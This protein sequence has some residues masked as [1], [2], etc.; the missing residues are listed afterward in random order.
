MNVRFVTGILAVAAGLGAVRPGV[1]ASASMLSP[2]PQWMAYTRVPQ[3][4]YPGSS[5]A[6]DSNDVVHWVQAWFDQD[7]WQ[8]EIRYRDTRYTGRGINGFSAKP[9]IL[10]SSPQGAPSSSPDVA[11]GPDGSVHVVWIQGAEGGNRSS[12]Y[13]RRKTSTGWDLPMELVPT[14]ERRHYGK[15]QIHVDDSGQI[16]VVATLSYEDA[17]RNL[18][19]GVAYIGPGGSMRELTDF[20]VATTLRLLSADAVYDIAP[21]I[22]PVS[23]RAICSIRRSSFL[24]CL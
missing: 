17:N 1:P 20:R 21:R 10:Y 4:T 15:P 24:S 5:I 7:L 13:Y 2:I 18:R 22:L 23:R 6:V 12:I 3:G 9:E 8:W 11:V 14:P 19:Q 16:H